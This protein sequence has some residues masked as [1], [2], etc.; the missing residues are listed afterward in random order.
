MSAEDTLEHEIKEITGRVMKVHDDL[1]GDGMIRGSLVRALLSD[2]LGVTPMMTCN[3]CGRS[4][5]HLKK[6][7]CDPC[8]YGLND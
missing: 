1:D 8:W 3:Q 4:Y 2:A 6:C 5:Y 7:I